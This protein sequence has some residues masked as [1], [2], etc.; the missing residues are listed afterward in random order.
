MSFTW[1]TGGLKVAKEDSQAGGAPQGDASLAGARFDIVNVSGKSALVGG[2][3]YGNGEVVKTIE[4]GWDAA[5]NAYVAAT[6][7][8]DLPCGIYEVVEEDFAL[9]EFV[10]PSKI[11][12]QQIIR[13]GI[14]LMIKEA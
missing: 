1:K 14:N 6:G 4:A 5:A 13:D 3:S 10:D 9:C 12:M 7:P 8:G 11:E 2:R